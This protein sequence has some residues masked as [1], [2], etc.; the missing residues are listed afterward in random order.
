MKKINVSFFIICIIIL[1]IIFFII[2]NVSTD[3]C[4]LKQ[5]NVYH[6]EN[7]WKNNDIYEGELKNGKRHGK[8]K[9]TY[10]D[11]DIYEGEFKDDK[12]DGYG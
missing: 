11:G 5:D 7:N 8:G 10:K 12:K 2:T 3:H 6:C 9:Y 1:V 4:K